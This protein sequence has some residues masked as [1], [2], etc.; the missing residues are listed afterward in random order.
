MVCV[1]IAVLTAYHSTS[2]SFIFLVIRVMSRVTSVNP[3]TSDF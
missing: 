3:T 2:L 1:K